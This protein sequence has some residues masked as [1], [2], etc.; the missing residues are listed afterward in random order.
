[1]LVALVLSGC[2]HNLDDCTAVQSQD[3]FFKTVSACEISIAEG[4][5]QNINAP[6]SVSYCVEI[7]HPQEDAYAKLNSKLVNADS[8]LKNT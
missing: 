8:D 6:V 1:M 2:S 4:Q 5:H 3:L 7:D